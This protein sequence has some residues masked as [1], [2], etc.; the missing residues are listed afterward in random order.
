MRTS[1]SPR[2]STKA[3][4]GD[5]QKVSEAHQGHSQDTV[6]TG[7]C[8]SAGGVHGHPT[9]ASVGLMAEHDKQYFPCP[10]PL[11]FASATAPGHHVKKA[12]IDQR[13]SSCIT[14]CPSTPTHTD[15]HHIT[16]SNDA[17]PATELVSTDKRNA[18]GDAASVPLG[19]TRTMPSDS[20][21]LPPL[22]P[23]DDGSARCSLGRGGGGVRARSPSRSHAY[24]LFVCFLAASPQLTSRLSPSLAA[25]GD[26]A[27]ERGGEEATRVL[28]R[29]GMIKH[30][31]TKRSIRR[32]RR[33]T[34][35]ANRLAP[36]SPAAAH[37]RAA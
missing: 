36:R 15:P 4:K 2:E 30:K 27:H 37:A 20:A 28:R 21:Q 8:E 5:E 17:A 13:A 24:C 12:I 7:E 26:G 35:Q 25:D 14:T 29:R 33:E 16:H 10:A 6:R 23:C 9:G 3:D 32:K 31:R 34:T 1:N 19:H 18:G 11:S 22:H